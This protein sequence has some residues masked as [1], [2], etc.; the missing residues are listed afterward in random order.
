MGV[1][2]AVVEQ[3]LLDA[4]RCIGCNSCA[5]ACYLG[6]EDTPGLWQEDVELSTAMPAICR[7]CKEAPCMAACPN[8]AI[9]EDQSGIVRRSPVRCT[10]CRTCMLACPFGV[11]GQ[12][13]VRREV[14][15]CDLC[16]DR[17][18][19]G[20]LPRCVAVCPSGALRFLP[21]TVEQDRERLKEEGY[22]LLS[23]RTITPSR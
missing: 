4:G 7:Q 22:V 15:K 11:I 3:L 16:A 14:G 18:P 19:D 8:D 21:I 20:R 9:Y 13:I 23:G 17:T 5:A 10:G 1:A 2:E 12:D 6:H